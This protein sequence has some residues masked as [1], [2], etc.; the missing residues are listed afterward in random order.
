MM[1]KSLAGWRVDGN[2][3]F[4]CRGRQCEPRRVKAGKCQTAGQET[5]QEDHGTADL[6]DL[7]LR[8]RLQQAMTIDRARWQSP[9]RC[10]PA[11]IRPLC[12]S[13]GPRALQQN[14][15]A[16]TRLIGAILLEQS[17]EWATQRSRYMSLET[18]STVSDN[19]AASLPAVA[20]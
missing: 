12:R 15:A 17:D 18:I 5:G 10:D 4:L 3:N 13:G 16:I 14:D 1:I 7:T 11:G 20:G 19:P 6:H 9:T 8:I 2:P